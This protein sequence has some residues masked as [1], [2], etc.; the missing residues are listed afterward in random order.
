LFFEQAKPAHQN[1][2]RG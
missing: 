2:H 1:Q